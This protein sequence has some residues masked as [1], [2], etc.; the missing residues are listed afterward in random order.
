METTSA[1]NVT[2]TVQFQGKSIAVPSVGTVAELKQELQRRVGVAANEQK[3]LACGKQ[4]DET[5]DLPRHARVML[6]RKP[7][8]RARLT[9]RDTGGRVVSGVEVSPTDTVES[10][11]ALAQR[12]LSAV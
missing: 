1:A 12:A 7:A 10:V 4:L 9:L 2:V 5:M 11:V 6:M 3:L 8:S